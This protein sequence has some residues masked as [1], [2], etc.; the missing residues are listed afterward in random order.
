MHLFLHFEKTDIILFYLLRI[1]NY[2]TISII[3]VE[4]IHVY[5]YKRKQEQITWHSEPMF[6][7]RVKSSLLNVK[8]IIC[9]VTELQTLAQTLFDGSLFKSAIIHKTQSK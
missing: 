3:R 4:N 1:S 5:F 7:C 8:F 6:S 2:A 9:K